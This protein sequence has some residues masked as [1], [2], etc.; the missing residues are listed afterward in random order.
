[1]TTFVTTAFFFLLGSLVSIWMV[2]FCAA[3]AFFIKL[4]QE[5]MHIHIVHGSTFMAVSPEEKRAQ[6]PRLIFTGSEYSF[7]PV[8][9][10]LLV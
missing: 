2:K 10:V 5:I 4:T 8:V 1:M 6:S 3:K 9:V 7:V